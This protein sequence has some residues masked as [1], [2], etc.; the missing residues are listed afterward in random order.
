[1]KNSWLCLIWIGLAAACGGDVVI[2]NSPPLATVKQVPPVQWERLRAQRIFFGH[3]S[4]G[5][6]ILEGVREVG[7]DN[8]Q[9]GLAVVQLPTPPRIPGPQFAHAYV[10][11]NGSPASKTDQFVELL[12]T[13]GGLDADIAFHKYCFA[14][15]E[16]E[17]DVKAVFEHYK[18]QMQKL[19]AARPQLTLVHVTVPLVTAKLGPR[20]MLSKLIGRTPGAYA[21]DIRRDEFNDLLR[22]EYGGKAPI[23][24]LAAIESTHPDG[25]RESFSF[26]GRAYEALAPEYARDGAH[27]NETG[28][29]VV[30][31]QMLVLLADLSQRR[32]ETTAVAAVNPAGQR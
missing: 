16:A 31:E 24:D 30:A 14:D 19:Q 12:G 15:I 27:L 29:R 18:E 9:I 26:N 3:Q 23:F 28:R 10:G 8:P 1:M 13:D 5:D 6:N 25:R 4:V 21:G 7:R 17:T 11:Q 22:A 2:P 20:G 32:A